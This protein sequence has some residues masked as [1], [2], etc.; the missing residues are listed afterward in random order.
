MASAVYILCALTSIAC[1]VM[2]LRG[3]LR[4]KARFLLWSSLCF[5]GMMTN[6]LLLA[7][8]KVFFPD[9]VIFASELRTAVALLGL[10][11]LL[12]GLVWDVEA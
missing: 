12:F 8:D 9:R 11:L 5:L 3:Y 1:A 7:I 2:L 10:L 4:S 6:N